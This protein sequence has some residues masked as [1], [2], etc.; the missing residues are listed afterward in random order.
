MPP[1]RHV[2]YLRVAQEERLI[3]RQALDDLRFDGAGI[4]AFHAVIAACDALTVYHL[5]I[6][7]Q[8]QDHLQVLDLLRQVRLEGITQLRH[9][10]EGVLAVKN[11]VAYGGGGLTPAEAARVVTQAERVVAWVRERVGGS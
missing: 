8:G 7:S 5:G 3:A 6:K 1:A 9:Q 11:Q 2:A 10:V 4:N